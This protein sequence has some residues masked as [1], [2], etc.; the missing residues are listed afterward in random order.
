MFEKVLEGI[1]LEVMIL[2]IEKVTV[3]T[4]LSKITGSGYFLKVGEPL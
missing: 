1:R 3:D 4:P 2:Q